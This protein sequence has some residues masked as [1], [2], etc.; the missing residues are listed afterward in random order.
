M[1]TIILHWSKKAYDT[2]IKLFK[3]P[4]VDKIWPFSTDGVYCAGRLHIPTLGIGPGYEELAHKDNEWV[5]EEDM[6]NALEV[7][8]YLPFC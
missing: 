2:Y 6:L 8:C 4:P 3:K 7:Y 1:S 5:K